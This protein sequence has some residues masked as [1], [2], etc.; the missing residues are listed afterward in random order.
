MKHFFWLSTMFHSNAISIKIYLK[1][2]QNSSNQD[3]LQSRKDWLKSAIKVFTYTNT[4]A[5]VI[6]ACSLSIHFVT[7]DSLSGLS[8]VYELDVRDKINCCFLTQPKFILI[9]FACPVALVLA[10]NLTL[11]LIVFFKTK[12]TIHQSDNDDMNYLYL[13]LALIMGLSWLIYVVCISVIEIFHGS[14][15]VT[16]IFVLVGTLR[17]NLQ[18][19]CIVT[20]LF[21]GAT[22]DRFFNK[23]K[24]N[25]NNNN[26]NNNNNNKQ[27]K[28]RKKLFKLILFNDL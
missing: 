8:L 22:Y 3:L 13:K 19:L 17:I 12:T 27:S 15:L 10:I 26:N 23:K 9:F 5:F 25:K 4:S 11:F 14:F 7:R 2:K 6:I 20:C 21:W 16:Q 1:L 18:G 28:K 24:L